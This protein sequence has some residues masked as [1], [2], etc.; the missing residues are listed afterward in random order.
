M[1]MA[2]RGDGSTAKRIGIIKSENLIGSNISPNLL[3]I[4][5]NNNKIVPIFLFYLLISE[6]AQKILD[7]K[8]NKTAKK[9]K[10]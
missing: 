3:K 8:I 7:K 5:A 6:G 1:L 10:I 4:Q 9:K 2:V